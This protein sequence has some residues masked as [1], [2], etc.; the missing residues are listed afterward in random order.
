MGKNKNQD[1]FDKKVGVE[2]DLGGEENMGGAQKLSGE[3]LNSDTDPNSDT[4]YNPKH[5][6]HQKI[7]GEQDYTQATYF[8]KEQIKTKGRVPSHEQI[9]I[10]SNNRQ[11]PENWNS[12]EIAKLLN[13]RERDVSDIL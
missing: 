9:N 8:K 13:M 12:V 2:G 3:N 4:N 6:F 5:K 1:L 7:T 11:D 10:I